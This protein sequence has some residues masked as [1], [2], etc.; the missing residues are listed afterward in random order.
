ML[1]V[2][3]DDLDLGSK[4]KPTEWVTVLPPSA[5]QPRQRSTRCEQI[6]KMFTSVLG[7][8]ASKQTMLLTT[9]REVDVYSKTG[10]LVC[11]DYAGQC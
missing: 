6:W 3:F 4:R 9:R 1:E 11:M 8:G 2:D 10:S 7:S 5:H